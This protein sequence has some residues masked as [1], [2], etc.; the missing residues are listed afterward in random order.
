ME[1]L[2]TSNN[3]DYLGQAHLFHMYFTLITLSLREMLL[4]LPGEHHLGTRAVPSFEGDAREVERGRDKAKEK[5]TI[6]CFLLWKQAEAQ[7]P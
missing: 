5:K 2:K 6:Y 4:Q 7:R 3:E 1:D